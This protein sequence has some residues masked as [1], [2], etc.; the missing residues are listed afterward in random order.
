M[1]DSIRNG[2]GTASN[3]RLGVV[4][5]M[6]QFHPISGGYQSQALRL[7]E[8]LLRRD[9]DV[10][11]VTHRNATLAPYE[12]YRGIR[13]HRIRT[14]GTGHLAALSYL[15]SSLLWMIRHRR[16]FRLIHA[17][18][19]SSGLIAGLVGLLVRRPVICKLTSG[20]EIDQKRFRA[21]WLGR[22]KLSCL[23]HLVDRFVAITAKIERDLGAV[24][25]PPRQIVRIPN[26]VQIPTSCDGR[27]EVRSELAVGPNAGVV[28]FAGR[29]IP[30]KGLDWLLDAWS[31]VV[32]QRPSARLLVL[33]D[34]P[35]RAS[36]ERQALELGL[37]GSV[38]FLGYQKEVHRYLA[39][40]DVFVLPSRREGMSNAVLEAMSHGL[41]AVVA[42]DV[43]G[44]NREIVRDGMEGF[45]VPLEDRRQ[46]AEALATLLA[47]PEIRGRMGERAREWVGARFS[48]DEVAEQ[49]RSL[50][51]ALVVGQSRRAT[52]AQPLP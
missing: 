52:D 39:A 49:Y 41:P 22:L 42:D 2:A 51:E 18:R 34:G 1:K 21:T 24:G 35:E 50:Y 8:E 43:S 46:L 36:L 6:W 17:S 32:R 20:G 29:L 30:D 44:G 7:A 25:I 9:V 23:R 12:V 38:H 33:G 45:V 5:L 19:S 13:I 48:I 11:V 37:S 16:T 27:D 28:T 3:G 40:S 31:E 15:L 10:Q 26:G 4:M 47:A 14:L